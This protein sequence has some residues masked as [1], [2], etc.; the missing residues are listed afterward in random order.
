MRKLAL[1]AVL[2]TIAVISVAQEH[3]AFYG[4]LP[5]ANYTDVSAVVQRSVLSDGSISWLI[6]FLTT[7]DQF[8]IIQND[9]AK[10]PK[11]WEYRFADV[12]IKFSSEFVSYGECS[13]GEVFNF[14]EGDT[15]LL[16]KNC[17][18]FKLLND[19]IWPNGKRIVA[20]TEVK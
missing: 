11:P 12:Y 10:N 18:T 6:T 16:L 2:L 7:G 1:L 5:E 3:R 4:M 17:F 20:L 13:F 8:L 9:I 14:V 19:K 15:G